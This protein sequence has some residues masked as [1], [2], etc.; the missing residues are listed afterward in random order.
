MN[1][2][3]YWELK[4][5]NWKIIDMIFYWNR[6]RAAIYSTSDSV[7]IWM[8]NPNTHLLDFW[9]KQD[10]ESIVKDMEIIEII[11]SLNLINLF[12]PID[13]KDVDKILSDDPTYIIEYTDIDKLSDIL[14]VNLY[15]DRMKKTE[16]DFLAAIHNGRFGK[17]PSLLFWFKWFIIK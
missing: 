10:D 13:L 2:I 11:D 5:L 16:W 17:W 9:I 15:K 7:L 8:T 1:T 4:K 3:T 14:D 12:I 6:F